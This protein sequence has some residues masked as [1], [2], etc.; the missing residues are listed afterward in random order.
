[1]LDPK[2]WRYEKA[3]LRAKR[4]REREEQKSRE[5][6]RP[7]EVLHVGSVVVH[8]YY[9]RGLT[10][11]VERYFEFGKYFVNARRTFSFT[12]AVSRHDL[13]DLIRAA[14]EAKQWEATRKR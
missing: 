10:G 14:Y 5:Y 2:K 13:D 11:S 8:C 6:L 3:W 7:Y 9:T 4:K 12:N 1:M